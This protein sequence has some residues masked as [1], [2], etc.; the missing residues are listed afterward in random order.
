MTK[1]KGNATRLCVFAMGIALA[2]PLSGCMTGRGNP[3]LKQMSHVE[4]LLREATG[5]GIMNMALMEKKVRRAGGNWTTREV[6]GGL[7]TGDT[8]LMILL[9]VDA[10][11][12]VIAEVVQNFHYS[13]DDEGWVIQMENDS[14]VD[15]SGQA[16]LQQALGIR[17][18]EFGENM[19]KT[20][21]DGLVEAVTKG[22]AAGVERA[23]IDAN[24]LPVP[25]S[26]L[27]QPEIRIQPSSP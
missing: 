22:F 7:G 20:I 3:G 5:N 8:D 13:S 14:I 24:K 19:T 17:Q 12:G 6:E 9:S 15:S 23:E 4:L 2:M 18:F 26:K 11:A 10:P 1:R 27:P 25:V 16:A 21:T